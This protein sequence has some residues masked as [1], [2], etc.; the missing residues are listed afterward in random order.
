MSKISS[1]YHEGLTRLIY[2]SK[3]HH[4]GLRSL[5]GHDAG[6]GELAGFLGEVSLNQ[7]GGVNEVGVLLQEVVNESLGLTLQGLA[8]GQDPGLF[9][10]GTRN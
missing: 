3:I 9:Y 10:N 4:L 7:L 8:A 2:S 6:A 1:W 5:C